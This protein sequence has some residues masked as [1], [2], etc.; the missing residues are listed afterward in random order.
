VPNLRLTGDPAADALLD[1]NP[2]AL[3]IGVLLDQQVVLET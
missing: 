2:F 3:F 1:D